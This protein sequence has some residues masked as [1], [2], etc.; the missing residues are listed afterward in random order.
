MFVKTVAKDTLAKNFAE[1][2]VVKK[3]LR[4]NGVIT[5]Q[6]YSKYTQNKPQTSSGKTKAKDS[7]DMDSLTNSLEKLTN[8][9]S[10][11]K[12]ISSEASSSNK[13]FKPF[14]KKN[15]NQL[16]KYAHISNVVFNVEVM[17]MENYYM[18]HQESHSEKTCSQWR[19][20]MIAMITNFLEGQATEEQLEQSKEASEVASLED[21]KSASEFIFAFDIIMCNEE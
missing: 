18:F 11:L 1:A 17:G 6:E 10:K 14:F 13:S 8:E 9:V 15:T 4:S 5:N 20:N 7:F 12:K 19:Y 3:H 16:A 2:I 21:N